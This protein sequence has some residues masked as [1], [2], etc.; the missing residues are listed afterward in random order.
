MEPCLQ[1][2]TVNVERI[3]EHTVEQTRL[4]FREG[5]ERV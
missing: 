4:Q 1:E 2:V 5:R 3:T